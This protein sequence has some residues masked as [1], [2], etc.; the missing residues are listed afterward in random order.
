MTR[1]VILG[2][3]GV[4]KTTLVKRV[5][6]HFPGLFHGF[7]TEEIREGRIRTGFRIV[8]LSGK[9][10]VLATKGGASPLRVGTYAVFVE[11]FER[12]VLPELENAL[13]Q[14]VPLLVDEIGEMELSSQN[15][16]KLLDILWKE[17]AFLLATSRFPGIPEVQ[18]LFAQPGTLRFFLTPKNREEVLTRVREL[19]GAF[20]K[21][22]EHGFSPRA[23]QQ[24]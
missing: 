20:T 2:R 9:R 16:R 14:K 24:W 8:T 13:K 23:P 7:Y 12:L 19:V 1:L 18:E 17:A 22:G 10:G 3:P 11:D 21:G 5:A 6:E 4:G 15:F